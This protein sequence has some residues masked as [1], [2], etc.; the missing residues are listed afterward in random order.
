LKLRADGATFRFFPGKQGCLIWNASG[1]PLSDER[2]TVDAS[3]Q[4]SL[5]PLRNS[6]EV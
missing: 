2:I 6:G 4:R 5:M 3:V 1:I